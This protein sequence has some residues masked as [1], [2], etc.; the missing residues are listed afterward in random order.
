MSGKGNTPT[1]I[2]LAILLAIFLTEHVVVSDDTTPIPADA[3]A[4]GG[5]F[6]ANIRAFRTRKATLDPELVV[7]EANP[8]VIT[9]RQDR[10]GNFKKINDA[11]KSIPSG[12][13][14]RVII[15]IGAGEYRGKI[16]IKRTK[17]FVTFYGSP[18][19]SPNLVQ[20]CSTEPWTAQ[21]SLSN[22]T[23]SWLLILFSRVIKALG[24][25]VLSRGIGVDTHVSVGG[26]ITLW[27]DN[28]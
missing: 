16:T 9:V 4:V 20:R 8:Q 25:S 23:I 10:T 21:P 5:W 12:N 17:P 18:N 2:H 13:T 15:W 7:A 1:A 19:V 3:S 28:L 24:D 26:L 11:I 27:N 14:R 6:S 22:L